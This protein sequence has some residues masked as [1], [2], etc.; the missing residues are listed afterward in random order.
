V[1]EAKGSVLLFGESVV[2]VVFIVSLEW[3]CCVNW[4]FC[5]CGSRGVS[6]VP[7]QDEIVA[8]KIILEIVGGSI[9]V[10]AES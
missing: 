1:E 8:L 3:D 6:G 4:K 5:V 7:S 10:R 2:G 9:L